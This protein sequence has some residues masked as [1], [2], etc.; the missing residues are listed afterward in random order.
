MKEKRNLFYTVF[1]IAAFL[2]LTAVLAVHILV[3]DR[4]TSETEKRKLAAFPEA[5]FR[6]LTDGSFMKKAETYVSDQFPGRDTLM[7]LRMNLLRLC[8]K[9]ESNGV[10]LA[11]DGSL[12]EAFP[13]YSEELLRKN[14]DAVNRFM[15]GHSFEHSLFLLVPTAVGT[16]PE[17]LPAFAETGDENAFIQSF[18]SALSDSITVL[19][20][21]PAIDR[22]K[23]SGKSVYYRTDHHWRTE[24][25]Y[26]VFL[27]C[28]GTAEWAEGNFSPGTVLRSFSG[29]LASKSGFT[30]DILDSITVY[31]NLNGTDGVLLEHPE[32]QGAATAG[33]YRSSAL[34]GSNPYEVFLG[35][36]EPEIVIRTTA[37]TERTLLILKDSY[38]NCF[39]PFLAD[40]YKTIT[41]VDPR[42]SVQSIDMILM[43]SPCTDVLFLYNASTLA[44]DENLK[45]VLD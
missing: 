37:D 19:D 32:S 25:A 28:C 15:D 6:A 33:F 16:Y 23:A 40:S 10:F 4:V 42:Y 30:P 27:D 7:K 43:A 36:N 21:K 1:G 13:E 31:E 9:K 41:V 14:A 20:P 39:L 5:D 3:P 29:S 45:I 34:S 12:I 18:T 8:G 26:E 22:I 17:K 44:E 11:E 24:T 2:L 35:G 38:A